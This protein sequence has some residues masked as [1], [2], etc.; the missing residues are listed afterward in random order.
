SLYLIGGSCMMMQACVIT[1]MLPFLQEAYR[2]GDVQGGLFLSMSQV[3]GMV[4]RPVTGVVSDRLF[5]GR[6]KQPLV[7]I[8]LLAAVTF[9]TLAFGEALLPRPLLPV[10]VGLI[11][12]ASVAWNGLYLLLS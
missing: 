4:A 9:A 7:L 10:W 8:A 11:G 1:F 2:I 12:V 6:R 3:L 5:L